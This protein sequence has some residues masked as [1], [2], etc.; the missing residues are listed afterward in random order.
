MKIAWTIL[1]N[2][3][4]LVYLRIY[5]IIYIHRNCTKSLVFTWPN[6]LFSEKAPKFVFMIFFL[7]NE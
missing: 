5:N 4:I 2:L 7:K 6:D 3:C 1:I